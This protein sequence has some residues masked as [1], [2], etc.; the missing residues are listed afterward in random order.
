[1]TGSR[2]PQQ[3]P[4]VSIV[5]PV[6]NG[7]RYVA[8]AIESILSQTHPDLEFLIVDDGSTD[9]TP[10]ILAR[11]A[12]LDPRV[13]VVSQANQG[14][15]VALNRALRM[16]SHAWV[17]IMDHDDVSLPTRLERQLDAVARYP[18]IRALGTDADLIDA[19]GVRFGRRREGPTTEAEFAAIRRRP[20]GRISLLH[21]SVLLHRDTV[22]R[23]GGYRAEFGVAAD[24]ELWSRV[25]DDHLVLVLPEALVRYRFHRQNMSF[26][27]F[28]VGQDM[29][30][31]I[32]ARQVARRCGLP[33]PDLEELLRAERRR[34]GLRRLRRLARDRSVYLI[35]QVQPALRGGHWPRAIALMAGAFALAPDE[36]VARVPRAARVLT[37]RS[38]R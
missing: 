5:M 34:F 20:D 16:A 35:W 11:Y 4:P 28:F 29:L 30:R 23:L 17:A 26:T 25:A 37:Q 15:P 10:A 14:Q 6:Y 8:E 2:S 27:Q 21:P 38:W 7:A 32:A 3:R 1:M 18:G 36:V 19:E 31:L 13:R 12:D 9:G 33:E 24:S 22:L